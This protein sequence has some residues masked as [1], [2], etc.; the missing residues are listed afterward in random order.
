MARGQ[1]HVTVQNRLP[2]YPMTTLDG[3]LLE[4]VLQLAGGRKLTQPP[5]ARSARRRVPPARDAQT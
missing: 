1:W 5:H 3:R 4:E 2:G